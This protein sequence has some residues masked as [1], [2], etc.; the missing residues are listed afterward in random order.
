MLATGNVSEPNTST[1][2][3]VSFLMQDSHIIVNIQSL[4]L[5]QRYY[6]GSLKPLRKAELG[7]LLQV[8]FNYTMEDLNPQRFRHLYVYSNHPRILE[9]LKLL[10]NRAQLSHDKVS[11]KQVALSAKDASEFLDLQFTSISVEK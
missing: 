3:D 10:C 11:Y 8:A 1:V 4:S 5:Q 2:A 7:F 6:F 9:C